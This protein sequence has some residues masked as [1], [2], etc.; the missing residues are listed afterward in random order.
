VTVP[1]Y[2][3]YPHLHGD[4]LTFVAEDDVWIAPLSGGRAW[5]LSADGV[6]VFHPRFSPDGR[7]VAW[8]SRRDG[9]PEVFVA[10]VEGGESRRLTYW[11]SMGTRVRGWTPGG[12]I[13]AV[14][15]WRQAFDH[16]TL[17]YA[18]PVDGEPARPL[19]WGPVGGADVAAGGAVA[20]VTVAGQEPARWKRYRG[21][22][23]GRLWVDSGDGFRRVLTEVA[24]NLDCP[25]WAGGRLAFLSDHEGVGRLY[26]SEP[27]GSGLRR[28]SADDDFY[29]RHASGDGERV[30]YQRAGDLW[31]VDGLGTEPVPVEVILGGPR[32]GRRTQAVAPR[33]EDLSC[34]HTG[35]A[36]AVEV[37]GGVYWLTHR[38]GPARALGATPGVR[39]R[40]PRVL[41]DTDQVVWV[42][43]TDEGDALEIS[44][45]VGAE[46]P[47]A[48]RRLAAGRLGRAE[49]LATAPDG[50]TVAVAA[51][52]GRLLLVDAAT[53][54]VT[55]LASGE[56]GPAGGL[57]FSPDSAWLAWTQ[58]HIGRLSR[59]RLARVADRSV[60]DVTDGR[61]QDGDPVFTTDGA[62]LVFLSWR[63]FEPV[64]DSHFFDLSFPFG[65]RPYLVPLDAAASSPFEPTPHGRAPVSDD[66]KGEE[67]N[68]PTVALGG[69][70]TRVVPFPV[71]DAQYS[72]LRAVRGGVVWLRRPLTG[73]LGDDGEGDRPKN[74][75]ERY[76]LAKRTCEEVT[77]GPGWLDVSGDG[78]RMVVGTDGGLRVLATDGS[79]DADD[80]AAKVDLSRLRVTVD[81]A[82]E[83]RQ[84]Y[85]EAGRVMR[86]Y[87]WA[88]H[89]NGVD[90]DGVL[91]RYRPLLDRIAGA[92]DFADLLREVFGELGTSHAYVSSHGHSSGEYTGLLGA[93]LERDDDRLWRVKR[94]LP[95]EVSD[96]YA[97]SPLA[98]PGAQVRSGDAVVA[99]NGRPVN[100]VT[101]PG[102]LL[103]GSY[104]T[105]TELTLA[106]GS[107]GPVRRIV[108]RPL[109]DDQRV[110]YQAWVADRRAE[111]RRLGDGRLGYL[112]IPDMQETGWAQF[113]RDL[114]SEMAAEGLL[115]DVRGNTGGFVSELV[116]EKLARR[117]V[118][119]D[120]GRHRGPVSYPGDAPRGP[121]V[122]LA[123][124]HTG[125]DGDI[126]AAAVRTLGLGTV[127]GRRTWGGVIGYEAY[128]WLVEGTGITVPRHATWFD[129][130]GWDL[131]NRGV[132]PDVEVVMGPDDWAQGRDPQLAAAVR[133][134][135]ERLAE[136]PA[137]MPPSRP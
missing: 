62:S 125:S 19:G 70:A 21:G 72:D 65:C 20:L 5:R 120:V 101:G 108:V 22:A 46:R 27:D 74:V 24:G 36:S 53:G 30:V 11:G 6:P 105:L 38:D 4:L 80:D 69:I 97:R 54:E 91:D 48:R 89:M 23:M 84:A 68:A 86:D 17:A 100:E 45:A 107:G 99:V 130:H 88:R 124:E 63:G 47:A 14:T 61:F 93:D 112:H 49:E 94:V 122:L 56:H 132:D 55:T 33:I 2:L 119:W 81:P 16:H 77:T 40:L 44:A 32:T 85:A 57:A 52:D 58:P 26:S 104:D 35:R 37:R 25:V 135:L 133:I 113:H 79:D 41:G 43:D 126:I 51:H 64:F 13:L 29:A 12:E 60:T 9:E 131:E 114:R 90:W 109:Y 50:T 128:H 66:D 78:R 83:W 87:F 96:P 31:L 75:L 59:I 115:V 3:R 10:P 137:A 127:V 34:D 15:P 42:T 136:R 67:R 123:D 73:T 98:A 117:V 82:V 76:D 106:P 129:G 1:G 95:V 92:D 39:A 7:W 118:G 121:V 18:V 110:R 134:A 111:V 103:T 102:P 8:S 116:V 28:H 71:P